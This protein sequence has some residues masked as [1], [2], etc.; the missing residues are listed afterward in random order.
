M[1][2]PNLAQFGG[3]VS[4]AGGQYFSLPF[5]FAR[6]GRLL[7]ETFRN[8]IGANLQAIGQNGDRTIEKR[9][10]NCH[11]SSLLD[12]RWVELAVSHG[13]RLSIFKQKLVQ[14]SVGPVASK[15][16]TK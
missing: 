6:D 10:V 4:V 15:I 7:L 8:W 5:A 3:L 13:K 1:G 12:S 9:L 16:R 14:E 2:G 11:L